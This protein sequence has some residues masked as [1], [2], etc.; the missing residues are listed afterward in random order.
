MDTDFCGFDYLGADDTTTPV[1]PAKSGGGS[2]FLAALE[3]DAPALLADVSDVV[4]SSTS[5]SSTAS[6]IADKLKAAG[7]GKGAAPA[8]SGSWFSEPQLGPLPGGA[9]LVLGLAVAGAL[10]FGVYKIVH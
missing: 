9:V 3:K 5:S 4:K 10:G 8:S 7:K 1:T 2:G 6:T